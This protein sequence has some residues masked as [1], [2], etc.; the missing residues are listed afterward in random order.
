MRLPVTKV[1]SSKRVRLTIDYAGRRLVFLD[2]RR[3]PS[4]KPGDRLAGAPRP[5]AAATLGSTKGSPTGAPNGTGNGGPR[6]GL[7]LRSPSPPY[8][9]T[10]IQLHI[11]GDVRVR[12][13]VENGS[14]VDTEGSGPPM[15]ASFAARWIKAKW[16]FNPTANGR[17][18]ERTD[19]HSLK[20]VTTF[21]APQTR[22]VQ[23]RFQ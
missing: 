6:T 4:I 9:P 7:L 16:K 12:I 14:I 17:K 15:L 2:N 3:K 20:L 21:G 11:T 18:T 1:A 22:P 10:P 19:F 23:G 5:N 8:P 13:T